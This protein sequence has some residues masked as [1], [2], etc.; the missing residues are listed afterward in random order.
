MRAKL[1][2]VVPRRKRG[3]SNFQ[4]Q[5]PIGLDRS[6]IQKLFHLRQKDAADHLVFHPLFVLDLLPET[7]MAGN[8]AHC[9]EECVQGL[10]SESLALLAEEGKR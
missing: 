4:R 6:A 1:H 7:W 8:I 10:G 5:D 2:F 3:E 9:I